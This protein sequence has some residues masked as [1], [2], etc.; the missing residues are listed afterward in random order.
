MT[1]LKKKKVKMNLIKRILVFLQMV[2]LGLNAD[3]NN[4][5]MYKFKGSSNL[6]FS[7]A[8]ASSNL[9]ESYINTLSKFTPAECI[10]RLSQTN[11]AV[12]ISYET[13]ENST[14][15]CKSY[16][17]LTFLRNDILEAKTKSMIFL[18]INKCEYFIFRITYSWK[19]FF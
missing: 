19:Y 9:L 7:S 12:A 4:Y 18:R 10:L 8:F 15:F 17:S 13:N 5:I 6:K 2:S 16:S 14:I 1:K 3:S 11:L